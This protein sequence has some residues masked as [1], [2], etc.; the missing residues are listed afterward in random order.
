MGEVIQLFKH[1]K[2]RVLRRIWPEA[3]PAFVAI[4][5]YGREHRLRCTYTEAAVD[6][7]CLHRSNPELSYTVAE[8]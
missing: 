4:D 8:I 7:D 5:Q 6:C 2:L 3:P 1:D